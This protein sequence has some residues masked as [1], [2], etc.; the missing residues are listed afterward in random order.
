MK[1][2]NVINRNEPNE[3]AFSYD[4]DDTRTRRCTC[5][6]LIEMKDDFIGTIK[7]P[8][9]EKRYM[10]FDGMVITTHEYSALFAN[11]ED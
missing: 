7:C 10:L 1:T 4:Y 8:C 2:I 11:D 9:R 3:I 5:G 6:K